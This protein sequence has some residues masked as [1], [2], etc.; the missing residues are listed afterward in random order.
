[1][2]APKKPADFPHAWLPVSDWELADVTA[3][4]AMERG[5]ANA[6][7]QKRALAWIINKACWTYESTYSPV[8]EHDGTFA[9]GRRF[10]GLQIV[11]LLKINA[12]AISRAKK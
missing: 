5:D 1:M 8:S 11:K 3:L 7:Q 6:D 12:A 9:Q 10:A 2:T 4:Q